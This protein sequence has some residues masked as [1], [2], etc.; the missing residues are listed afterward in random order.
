MLRKKYVDRIRNV[1][2]VF[3]DGD[4]EKEIIKIKEN[5]LVI[6][7]EYEFF[8]CKEEILFLL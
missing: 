6:E 1:I 5:I 7:K 8:N 2:S 4:F 3:L